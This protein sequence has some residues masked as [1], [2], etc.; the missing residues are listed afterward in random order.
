MIINKSIKTKQIYLGDQLDN[1]QNIAVEHELK[2]NTTLY[3][4]SYYNPPD[5][6]LRRDLFDIVHA[7]YENYVI[8][9]DLNSKSLSTFC[10][11]TNSNGAILEEILTDCP[12]QEA[13]DTSH[14]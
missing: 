8:C 6:V 11:S 5:V 9:G 12:C 2:D 14:N 4:V 3:L 1:A 7:R 10:S 13:N